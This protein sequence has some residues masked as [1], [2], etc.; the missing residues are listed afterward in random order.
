MYSKAGHVLRTETTLNPPREFKVCRHPDDDP[1]RPASRQKMRKGVA[2]LHWRAEVSQASHE[3]DL[4]RVAA[5]HLADRLL[6]TA[7]D[8][9][10]RI[11]KDGPNHRAIHPWNPEDFQTL[12]FLARGENPING[13]VNPH[14]LEALYAKSQDPRSRKGAAEKP[15]AD[16]ACSVRMA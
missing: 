2:D 1:Q 15:V 5:A 13:F 10:K 4:D 16:C 12:Q 7:G 14:L 8:I 9:C 11:R 3:R 6:E